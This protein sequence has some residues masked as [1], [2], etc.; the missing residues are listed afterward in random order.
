[1]WHRSLAAVA[2]L[3]LAF[4]WVLGAAP[5]EISSPKYLTLRHSGGWG[6]EVWE[7]TVHQDGTVEYRGG[8]DRQY[9]AATYQLDPRQ[10]QALRADLKEFNESGLPEFVP[11][12]GT[13]SPELSALEFQTETTFRIH[14]LGLSARQ[15]P[16]SKLPETKRFLKHWSRLVKQ[17]GV[18]NLEF[19]YGPKNLR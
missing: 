11:G 6:R 17:L 19:P 4:G 12:E 8:K 2:L 14:G 5:P 3:Q 15:S 1:M 10:M 9:R 13:D 7:L 16:A 18:P